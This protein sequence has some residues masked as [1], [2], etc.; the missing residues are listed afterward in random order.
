MDETTAAKGNQRSG[1][2][3]RRRSDID[4]AAVAER[5]GEAELRIAIEAT[6]LGIFDYYPLT[7]D[8]HWS[9]KAKEHFGLSPDAHVNYNVFLVGLHPEDRERVD[10]LVHS[11]LQKE[12]EGRYA[13]EYRTVGIEDGKD[14]WISASG[15]AFFNGRGEAV[16]FIGT[17]LD[18]TEHKRADE[19]LKRTIQ[20]LEKA[21]RELRR[22]K[23]PK[24]G[25]G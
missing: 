20:E 5:P 14:R 15:Q 16:R 12:T 23:E 25:K 13:T 24:P 22:F 6:G 8:L 11:V 1:P 7:G 4:R 17:T 21:N 18:V 9:H 10:R 19:E 3:F 2:Q